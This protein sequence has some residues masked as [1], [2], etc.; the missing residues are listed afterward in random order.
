MNKNFQEINEFVEDLPQK[1][2]IEVSLYI[3]EERYKKIKFFRKMN[4]SFITWICPLMKPCMFAENQ[5]IFNESDVVKSIYFQVNGSSAFVLPS[6]DNCKYI[7][8]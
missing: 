7:D 4:A 6:Y 5:Y 1:L 2:R 8:I 3:Y